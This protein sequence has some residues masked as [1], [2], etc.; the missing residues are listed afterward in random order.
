[1]RTQRPRK[2]NEYYSLSRKI[3]RHQDEIGHLKRQLTCLRSENVRL[4]Q[5]TAALTNQIAALKREN[6]CLKWQARQKK[7]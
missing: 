6:A 4:Q 7:S 5:H 1:M 2:S 3:E